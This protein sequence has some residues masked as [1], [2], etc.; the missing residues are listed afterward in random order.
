MKD[1]DTMFD[2]ARM[3]A[4]INAEERKKKQGEEVY[5]V[6]WRIDLHSFFL[7]NCW[8]PEYR[9][10]YQINMWPYFE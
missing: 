5:N 7:H 2:F 10:D 8:I 9:A 6:V 1:E 3:I 4:A